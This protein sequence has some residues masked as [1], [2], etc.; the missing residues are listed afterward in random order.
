M[1]V[2]NFALMFLCHRKNCFHTHKISCLRKKFRLSTH[3]E[4][5]QTQK[6]TFFKNTFLQNIL[7]LCCNSAGYHMERLLYILITFGY[8][9][10]FG[11]LGAVTIFLHTPKEK[12]MEYYRRARTTLGMSLTFIAIYCII[13]LVIPQDHA[14]Y[15]DFWL[16][17]NFTLIH[18]WLTYTTMLFL[19]ESPRYR[20]RHFI[21][22][23]AVPVS[24][25]IVCGLAGVF[26]PSIRG[27]MQVIFGIIFG[28]KCIY[29][30]YQCVREYYRC[31]KEM[32][33]YYDVNPDIRWIKSLIY[34]SLFM[35]AATIVAFYVV[36]IHLIYYL[37]IPI[38]YIYIV[39]KILNFA[40]KKIDAVR[41]KNATMEKPAP[42][43]KKAMSIDEK[44]GPKVDAWVAEK[45]FCSSE[46]NIKDVAQEIGTNQNY[47]SQYINNYLDTSF[48]V[49]LNTLRIEESKTLLT[50]GTKRS[51]E[52]VG[53]LVGFS[54]I[55]NFSRWFRTVT[56][57]TPFQYRKNN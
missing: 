17:V 47:L 56:G 24:L 23:G 48:Q 51:I 26:I 38:I 6:T 42:E 14:K 19:L 37:S 46:L 45:K 54:Q 5:V 43:K 36:Q 15:V 52:E 2:A 1:P 16:L 9:L 20:I 12:G 10:I 7:L 35:S 55:Y 41:K 39:F 30:F 44:I 25:M 29:M 28:L 50:D 18:S 4:L 3:T 22:D 21:V 13:R 49:W 34:L 53:Q 27:W 8:V 40:P 11:I 31:E 32:N 33:N 57:T